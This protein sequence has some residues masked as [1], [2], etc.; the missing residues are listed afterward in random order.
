[1]LASQEGQQ[2]VTHEDIKRYLGIMAEDFGSKLQLVIEV[3]E[4]NHRYA[5]EEFSQLKR[6]RNEDMA[7]LHAAIRAVHEDL[8]RRIDALDQKLTIRMDR[9]DAR[10]DGL[11]VRMDRLEARMDGIEVRMDRLEAQMVRIHDRLDEQATDITVL[12]SVSH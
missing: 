2:P 7:F 11:E 12:K 5:Q 1:M 6:Q 3:V 10:M 4:A 8:G 9:L